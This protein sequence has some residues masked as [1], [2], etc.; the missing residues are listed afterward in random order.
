V[1]DSPQGLYQAMKHVGYV[2]TDYN[3]EYVI[4]GEHSESAVMVGDNMSTDILVG[5]E[6]ELETILVLT[7]FTRLESILKFPYRPDRVLE[8]VADIEL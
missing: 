8:S 1:A 6:S 5:L 2:L 3:P 7:G 4:Q